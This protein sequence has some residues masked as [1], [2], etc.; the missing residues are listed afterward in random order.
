MPWQELSP[1]NLRM[2]FVTDW[3][4]GCW[5]MTELCADYQISRKTGYKWVERYETS[6][7]AGLARSVAAPASQSAGDRCR[8]GRGAGGACGQ[9]HPRWGAKKLLAVARRRIAH[10]AWPS[11]STVCDLLKARGLVAPRRRRDRPPHRAPSPLGADHGRERDVDDGFQR[12]LS[13]GRRRVL[14]S[15]DAARWLQS[16]RAAL[17]RVARTDL[18]GHAPALR[19]RVRRVWIARAHSQ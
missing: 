19:T 17:R 2:H 9:R 10:A 11:R 6:G 13:H 14:L 16:L 18:R 3:Q 1:V 12:P 7:P 4:T 8:A 5:T 15:A